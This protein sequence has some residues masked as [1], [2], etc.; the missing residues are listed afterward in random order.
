MS[1]KVDKTAASVNES[2]RRIYAGKKAELISLEYK[3]TNPAGNIIVEGK[4]ESDSFLLTSTIA[5]QKTSRR[6]GRPVEILEDVMKTQL[7]AKE[8]GLG[9]ND[10]I[11]LSTFVADP[12]IASIMSH[13]I[14]V[15]SRDKMIFGGV[16]TDVITILDSV[17]SMGVGGD[18][19]ISDNGRILEQR[20]A[21]M[22][23]IIKAEPEE[24]ANQIDE[25][26]DLLT[27]NLIL[28]D[29]GP[30][31]SRL[32]EKATYLISGYDI[33]S[34]PQSNATIAEKYKPDSALVTIVKDTFP[35]SM[36]AIPIANTAL[37]EFLAPEQLIQSTNPEIIKQAKEIIGGEKDPAGAAA[38]IID[39]VY[40][41]IKKEYS[42]EL[43]N[44]LAT[45]HSKKGDCGE[46]AALA[47]ALLRAAGIPARIA[48]GIVYWPEGKG[49]A[50]H[51]WIEAYMG[52][53]IQMDPS[54]GEISA[55]ATHIMLSNG[56]IEKQ[57]GSIVGAM[58]GMKIRF[59]SF[60]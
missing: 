44:A 36:A 51:A 38:I 34:L 28:V 30:A 59:V 39:W 9:I 46:H 17:P 52:K 18:V 16:P 32:V 55:N 23:I 42:P 58:R 20:I 22:A 54:W 37:A 2:E 11:R 24:I 29:S 19:V 25:S 15:K 43:S 14:I 5:G 53:W 56:G 26:F 4:A 60:E 45:L 27:N 7:L 21:G 41:N 3:A 8:N 40:K 13:V 33:S 6:F 49:F 48:S 31:D 1:F 47:T 12:P 50:Y 10:T 57:I 35:D